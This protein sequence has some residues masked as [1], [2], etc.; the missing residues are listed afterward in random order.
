M[1]DY[2]TI[3]KNDIEN[4]YNEIRMRN[5][6]EL[7]AR[8]RKIFTEVPEL[9]QLDREITSE[10]AALIRRIVR[11]NPEDV[12]AAREEGRAKVRVLRGRFN[13]LLS[14]NGYTEADLTISYDC[15]LCQDA[16]FVDG[17]RCSCYKKHLMSLLYRQS[18]LT[19]I[20]ERENFGTFSFDLY[21]DQSADGKPS[22]RE[23]I[24]YYYT[25]AKDFAES[26]ELSGQS[27][28][29]YG[30][31]GI[32]KTFLSNCI[33]KE[34]MDRG[35]SVL[36]V[37]ANQLFE[38]ILSTYLMNSDPEQK[39]RV[40]PVYDLVYGADLLVLDDLGTEMTNRFTLS[41]L[42]EVINRRMIRNQSTIISTNLSLKQLRDEYQDRIVSRIVERY[43]LF[44]FYGDNI[45]SKKKTE[46]LT[47]KQ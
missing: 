29:F 46:A 4:I 25:K 36:Y 42:F 19:E 30:S 47:D 7:T 13:T 27:F 41:Q 3:G 26:D 10:N 6:R 23:C 28:L 24:E 12:N 1:G 5:E 20:L 34:L 16:G 45:R 11:L 35:H 33:A 22:P 44:H 40:K 38:D 15:P 8:R 2:F 37:T 32:G 17:H 18:G 31:A 14:E 39:D 9:E 21:S 43:E